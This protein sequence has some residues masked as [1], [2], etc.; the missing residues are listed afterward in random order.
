MALGNYE[1]EALVQ[2]VV[3]FPVWYVILLST[4]KLAAFLIRKLKDRPLGSPKFWAF[5]LSL[6]LTA[7]VA[8][9]KW[10]GVELNNEIGR[11]LT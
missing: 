10:E 9:A 3:S 6:I 8:R 2:T 1:L 4:F 7:V 11:S 5:S